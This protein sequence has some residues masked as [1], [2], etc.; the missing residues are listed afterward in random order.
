MSGIVDA[1]EGCQIQREALRGILLSRDT[2]PSYVRQRR[3]AEKSLRIFQMLVA[4][5]NLFPLAVVILRDDGAGDDGSGNVV[6][7][8][9]LGHDVRGQKLLVSIFRQ[10][11]KEEP[12]RLC[13]KQRLRTRVPNI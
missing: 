7:L 12:R 9:R 2:P 13:S 3:A 11:A 4:A 5:K 6:V 10:I 8:R 1:F